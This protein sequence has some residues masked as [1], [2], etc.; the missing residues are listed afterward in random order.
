MVGADWHRPPAPRHRAAD[1]QRELPPPHARHQNI[2]P[3][4]TVM[5]EVPRFGWRKISPAGT[6]TSSMAGS[7]KKTLPI[8]F[9]VARA[10]QVASSSTEAIFI[11]SLGCSW[12][13]PRSTQRCAP[14]PICPR[15]ATSTSR[16]SATPYGKPGG[17][18]DHLDV[19]QPDA[20]R[21]HQAEGEAQRVLGGVQVGV[22]AAGG[23]QRDIAHPRHRDQQQHEDPGAP[24][25][26]FPAG[27]AR[28]SGSAAAARR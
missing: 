28:G 23:I 24:A 18:V 7:R 26:A 19:H 2:T 4:A 27:C 9:Q 22:A 3:T 10:N 6:K 15:T 12:M 5:T 11:S 16:P 21:H 20:Q 25:T 14:L 13:G 17:A 8:F 1:R